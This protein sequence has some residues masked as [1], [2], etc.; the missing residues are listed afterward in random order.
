MDSDFCSDWTSAPFADD[1]D[2][3]DDAFMSGYSNYLKRNLKSVFF[4]FSWLL[5]SEHKLTFL[6]RGVDVIA[7]AHHGPDG[8]SQTVPVGLLGALVQ[9]S[10]RHQARITSVLQILVKKKEGTL[11][12]ISQRDKM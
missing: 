10:V 6:I 7:V 11:F 2:D 3:G 8:L 4:F 1:D 12:K 9:Q 5:I